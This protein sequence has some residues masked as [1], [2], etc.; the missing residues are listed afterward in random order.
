MQWLLSAQLLT[1]YAGAAALMQDQATGF[2]RMGMQADYLCSTRS[3]SE[4]QNIVTKLHGSTL[5]LQL[6][7]ITPES[8]STDQ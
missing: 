3:E 2:Q 6:L 1:P 5:G 7:L 8:L 4:R